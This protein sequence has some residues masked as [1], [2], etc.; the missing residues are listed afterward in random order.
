[1]TK[2][3]TYTDIVIHGRILDWGVYLNRGGTSC[4]NPICIGRDLLGDFLKNH[5]NLYREGLVWVKKPHSDNGYI[6]EAMLDSSITDEL[7]DSLSPID[8]P[9]E[10]DRIIEVIVGP[11]AAFSYGGVINMNVKGPP[12]NNKTEKVRLTNQR[13]L[14]QIDEAIKNE[15]FELAAKLRNKLNKT[16]SSK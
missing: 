13:L 7:I 11:D 16:Q 4:G 2:D 10:N 6:F 8:R 14:E 3:P 9:R 12:L 1:M 15:D 5:R